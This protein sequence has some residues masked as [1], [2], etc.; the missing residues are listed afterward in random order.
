MFGLSTEL[1]TKGKFNSHC[2]RDSSAGVL[3]V[4]PS[5]TSALEW[6]SCGRGFNNAM[7]SDVYEFLSVSSRFEQSTLPHV[8]ILSFLTFS[9]N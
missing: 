7:E 4:G 2:N 5:D 6:R 8:K 3:S 1:I 9:N